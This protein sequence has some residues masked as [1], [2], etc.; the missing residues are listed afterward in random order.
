MGKHPSFNTEAK[1]FCEEK[2]K[3]QRVEMLDYISQ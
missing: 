3:F 2:T 1:L